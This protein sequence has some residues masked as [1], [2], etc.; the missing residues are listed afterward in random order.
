MGS[1]G[2]VP[3]RSDQRR[4]TNQD[5]GPITKG[6]AAA[7]TAIPAASASWHP[8][9]KKYFNALKLSGETQY[10]EPSDWA[11]AVV[12]MEILSRMLESSRLSAQL[13]AAWTA[14][15][16]RLLVTE[17]DRRRMRLELEREKPEDPDAEAG[18]AQMDAW[19]D[20]LGASG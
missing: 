14:D 11:H 2:P 16:A 7:G 12:S 5:E 13:Y 4:R 17:G 20:R 18:V 15:T 1:R 3:K 10:F 8:L 9:A 19:R 6:R